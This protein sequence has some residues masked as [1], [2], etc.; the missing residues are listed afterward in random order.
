MIQRSFITKAWNT[1]TEK[2]KC[3]KHWTEAKAQHKIKLESCL[4]L[5]REYKPK[6]YLRA[7]TDLKLGKVLTM[8]FYSIRAHPE[9]FHSSY[10]TEVFYL[11][12]NDTSLVLFIW[13]CTDSVNRTSLYGHAD[14]DRPGYPKED[15]KR[16]GKRTAL[17]NNMP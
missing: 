2:K 3:F 15:T 14:T 4:F 9:M 8:Y 1:K 11:T 16:S 12:L 17:F 10:T 7:V 6:K 13:P 5:I